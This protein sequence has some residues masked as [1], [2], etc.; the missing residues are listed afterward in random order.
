MYIQ[1]ARYILKSYLGFI[2]KGK[3]LS[4]SVKYIEKFQA[5]QDVKFFGKTSWTAYDLR[6]VLLK[7]I[8]YV[9]GTIAS[10]LMNKEKRET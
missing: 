1:T 6:T 7:G 3:K 9:L 5:V 2:T 10:R 8:K 4:D